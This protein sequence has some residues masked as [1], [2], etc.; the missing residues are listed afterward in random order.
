MEA[1]KGLGSDQVFIIGLNKGIFPE[2]GLKAE[3]LRE[4]QRLLYVSMTR[5]K[6]KLHMFYSRTREG[7]LSFQ[8]A[9]NGEGSGLLE[10][11]LFIEWI[12]EKNF[13]FEKKWPAKTNKPST[14]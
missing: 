10:P 3:K 5:A 6:K 13:E 4:R 2:E 9:P 8:P 11:S 1:A 7:R 12:P 14:G